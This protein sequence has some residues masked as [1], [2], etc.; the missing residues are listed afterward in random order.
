MI[1]PTRIRTNTRLLPRFE[2]NRLA[3]TACQEV[4]GV[5]VL[6]APCRPVTDVDNN[7]KVSRGD[8]DISQR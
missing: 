6:L 5:F 8:E 7:K 3:P 2:A 1:D 4:V